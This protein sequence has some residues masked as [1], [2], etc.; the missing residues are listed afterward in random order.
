MEGKAPNITGYFSVY[1]PPKVVLS[2][3]AVKYLASSLGWR[4]VLDT[5]SW[6]G[7]GRSDARVAG[8]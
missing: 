4:L 3:T 2:N 7:K 1:T 8:R 6:W 5:T